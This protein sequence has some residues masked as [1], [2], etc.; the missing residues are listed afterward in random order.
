MNENAKDI[1]DEVKPAVESVVNMLIDDI[2]NKVFK[3]LPF[4]KVFPKN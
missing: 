4:L 1:I 3:S 2:V